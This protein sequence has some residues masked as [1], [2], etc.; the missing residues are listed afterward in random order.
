[1]LPRLHNSKERGFII[2]K[3][4]LIKYRPKL[5]LVLWLYKYLHLLLFSVK[6]TKYN[7]LELMAELKTVVA[8][9]PEKKKC[10]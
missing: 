3:H 4:W 2:G 9:T 10:I 1:M 8:Q 6:N 5:F 7:N